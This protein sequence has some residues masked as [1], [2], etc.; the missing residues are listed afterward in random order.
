MIRKHRSTCYG[1]AHLKYKASPIPQIPA[2][3][4]YSLPTAH[5]PGGLGPG[6]G[7][8]GHLSPELQWWAELHFLVVA[9]WPSPNRLPTGR[10]G[11]PTT[12]WGRQLHT[13]WGHRLSLSSTPQNR[14][15]NKAGQGLHGRPLPA[16]VLQSSIKGKAGVCGGSHKT[17]RPSLYQAPPGVCLSTGQRP[18][19]QPCLYPV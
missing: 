7:L 11:A 6:W 12:V 14:G 8:K 2:T 1:Q 10:A 4:S 3:G 5:P 19:T 13:H 17:S 18:H 15:L 16:P 9:S